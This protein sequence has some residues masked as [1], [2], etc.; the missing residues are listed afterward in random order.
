MLWKMLYHL[1]IRYA[2]CHV[3]TSANTDSSKSKSHTPW[4]LQTHVSIGKHH[5]VGVPCLLRR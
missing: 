4:A 5:S 1:K 3:G 2:W